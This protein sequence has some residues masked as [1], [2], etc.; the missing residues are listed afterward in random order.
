VGGPDLGY[1]EPVRAASIF[2]LCLSITSCKN[3]REREAESAGGDIKRGKETLSAKGNCS[4]CHS[5]PETEGGIPPKHGALDVLVAKAGS[6]S[7]LE[8]AIQHPLPSAKPGDP[9]PGAG[10]AVQDVKDIAAY[11]WFVRR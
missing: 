1:A 9:T 7:S 10:L 3:A 2:L 8:K 4:P 5:L 11:L 6:A